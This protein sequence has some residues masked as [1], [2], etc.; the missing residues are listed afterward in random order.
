MNS[1]PSELH[2][3]IINISDTITQIYFR[4]THKNIYNRTHIYG[5][6]L[7]RY[8]PHTKRNQILRATIEDQKNIRHAS[9]SIC[10]SITNL[11]Y[12]K[13][14]LTVCDIGECPNITQKGI[15]YLCNLKKFNI[16]YNANIKSLNHMGRTLISCTISNCVNVTQEGIKDLSK[17]IHLDMSHCPK[18][19][20]LEMCKD[21]LEWLNISG[22]GPSISYEGIKGLSK[23]EYLDMSFNHNIVSL[24]CFKELKILVANSGNLLSQKSIMSCLKIE[25]LYLFGID[26]YIDQIKSVNHL[27]NTL[28]VLDIGLNDNFNQESI[29]DLKVLEKISIIENYAILSLSHVKDT[30]T[31]ININF[32]TM[33][34]FKQIELLHKLEAIY[35]IN[36]DVLT[37]IEFCSN[38]LKLLHI[39]GNNT[40]TQKEFEKAIHI[41]Y[42][43]PNH[44]ITSTKHLCGELTYF[45]AMQSDICEY[46]PDSYICRNL[47]NRYYMKFDI[48]GF[49]F[50]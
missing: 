40:L 42:L 14:T 35:C 36:N 28:R 17:L 23:L 37:S 43:Y 3:E 38:T 7:Q 34:P 16:M 22:D 9:G 15:E 2:Q 26:M 39:K 24:N 47:H 6:Q 45:D 4:C 27:S 8:L 10:K 11:N 25:E 46:M 50:P 5:L 19:S 41:K 44:L 12:L 49:T 31:H 13:N 30:L 20:S 29:K 21:T 32:C 1:L 33:M 18:I 48:F